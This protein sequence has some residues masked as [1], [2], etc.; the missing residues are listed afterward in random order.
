MSAEYLPPQIQDIAVWLAQ[1]SSAYNDAI[2]SAPS[3]ILYKDYF[4]SNILPRQSAQ[5]PTCGLTEEEKNIGEKT[6][7]ASWILESPKGKMCMVQ[8]PKE[9]YVWFVFNPDYY[10]NLISAAQKLA[11]IADNGNIVYEYNY[12]N[13]AEASALRNFARDNLLIC[14]I[15]GV[16]VN[17]NNPSLNA[18][19]PNAL[20]SW[21]IPGLSCGW[22]VD[23]DNARGDPRFWNINL[24]EI[25]FQGG[26]RPI[27]RQ[28]RDIISSL[29]LDGEIETQQQSAP[30]PPTQTPVPQTPALAEE[31][32]TSSANPPD[33]ITDDSLYQEISDPFPSGEE[34]F[35]DIGIYLGIPVILILIA[36]LGYIALKNPESSSDSDIYV[37][38]EEEMKARDGKSDDWD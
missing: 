33:P 19:D 18:P 22:T 12:E 27:I 11:V 23:L 9:A 17:N 4:P 38:S 3:P 7:D 32:I 8:T 37:L 6:I 13:P 21:N 1:P 31:N 24:G 16:E 10:L 5:V 2:I 26:R 20:E 14:N 30:V 15:G 36:G 29:G 35:S 28:L 34:V 25:K